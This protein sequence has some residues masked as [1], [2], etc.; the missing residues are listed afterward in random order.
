[1]GIFTKEVQ[2]RRFGSRFSFFDREIE[3]KQFIDFV[4]PSLK[5]VAHTSAKYVR[6]C[7][8]GKERSFDFRSITLTETGSTIDPRTLGSFVRTATVRH[9][10]IA[11]T[12]D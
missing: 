4:E 5:W 10:H 2:T 12:K 11:T 1:M 9:P 8:S 7:Q 3:E 6:V